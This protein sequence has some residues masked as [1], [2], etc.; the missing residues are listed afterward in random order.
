MLVVG[1]GT[2]AYPIAGVVGDFY[3]N[4]FHQK[5]PPVIIAHDPRLENCIAIKTNLGGKNAGDVQLLIKGLEKQWKTVYPEEVFDYAF[6]DDAVKRLYENELR[7]QQLVN[8][9]TLIAI[10]ISCMGLL[11]LA[12][13]TAEKRT[14]EIGIRK[15]LGASVINIITMLSRDMVLL[16]LLSLVIASP[17]AGLLVQP[18]LQ[19]FA[20][21]TSMDVWVFVFAG[22]GALA[23]AFATT[24]IQTIRSAKRNPVKSLRAE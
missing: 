3:E 18:W 12:M 21:R 13:F 11:G 4:S 9:A 16:I 20:Y 24:S 5:I 23:I 10:F 1:G 17:I 14:K 19:S 6:L 2:K 22:L 15:V 7:L 8:S